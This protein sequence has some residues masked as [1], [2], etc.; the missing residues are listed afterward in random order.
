MASSSVP[1]L[2]T[3]DCVLGRIAAAQDGQLWTVGYGRTESRGVAPSR[4]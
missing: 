1:Y 4:R 3:N 2:A